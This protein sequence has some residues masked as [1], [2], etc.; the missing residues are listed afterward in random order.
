MSRRRTRRVGLN[1]GA[2]G[3]K[4]VRARLDSPKSEIL[5]QHGGD[6]NRRK[7]RDGKVMK[8]CKEGDLRD[9]NLNHK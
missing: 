2:V 3:V 9:V 6:E 5:V 7:Q 4:V 1:S 8:E